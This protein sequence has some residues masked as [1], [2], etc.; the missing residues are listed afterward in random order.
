MT[1]NGINFDSAKLMS[2]DELIAFLKIEGENDRALSRIRA[3]Y[4]DQFGC[5]LIWRCPISDGRYLGS[6]IAA[7]CEGFLDLPYDALDQK[8]GELFDLSGARLLDEGCLRFLLGS[9]IAFSDD[10][11]SAIESMIGGKSRA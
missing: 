6:C 1:I 3:R 11:I 5:E 9:F 4:D 7:V 8:D 10:L 2:K